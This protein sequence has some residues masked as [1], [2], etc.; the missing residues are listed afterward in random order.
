MYPLSIAEQ[1]PANHASC[2]FVRL[3][4]DKLCQRAIA[5]INF[6]LGYHSTKLEVKALKAGAEFH[7]RSCNSWS[8]ISASPISAQSEFFIRIQWNT[9]HLIDHGTH[10]AAE[11]AAVHATD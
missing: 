8:S 11:Y 2:F 5:D 10:G 6:S 4:P 1:V 7:T 3:H 9:P